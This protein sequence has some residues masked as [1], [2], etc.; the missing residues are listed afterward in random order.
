[1]DD[2]RSTII[3]EEVIL[4]SSTNDDCKNASNVLKLVLKIGL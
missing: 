4:L 2:S 3:N 1:M